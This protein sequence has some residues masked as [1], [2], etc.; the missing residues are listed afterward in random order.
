M[1][2]EHIACALALLASTSAFAA[3]EITP[4]Q[5]HAVSQNAQEARNVTVGRSVST[6]P[7]NRPNCLQRAPAISPN[8]NPSLVD[9]G[10]C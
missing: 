10:R 9:M 1:R 2:L 8:G 3:T 4:V 6:A 7:A 5:Y